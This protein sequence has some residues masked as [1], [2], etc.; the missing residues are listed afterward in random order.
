MAI[1][2]GMLGMWHSH[3][4]GIVKQVAAH[5][6]EFS[7]VAFYDP[8]PDV[9]ARRRTQWEPHLG[10]IKICSSPEELVRENLDGVVVDGRVH[11]N[12]AQARLALE[13]GHSV[14]LEKPAGTSLDEYRQLI[15]LAERK[16]LHVQMVYLFRYMSAVQEMF[17]LAREGALGNI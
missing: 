12:V 2:L 9:V 7:L 6:D 10:S 13:H 4:D 14:M 5:P 15:D 17:R 1:R 8:E 16:H 3:A 11:H